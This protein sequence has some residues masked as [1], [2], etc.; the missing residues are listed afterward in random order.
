M[1]V[2]LTEEVATLACKELTSEP[3]TI[4]VMCLKSDKH[5]HTLE[6]TK[7][8]SKTAFYFNYRKLV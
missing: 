5:N 4:S 8:Y 1:S 3:N 7:W 2:S 6:E